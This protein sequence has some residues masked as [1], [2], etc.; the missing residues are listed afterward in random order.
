MKRYVGIDVAQEESALCIVNVTGTILFVGSCA[1][2][3]D[4]IIQTIA[5]HAGDEE[6]IVH[7]SGLPLIWLTRELIKR[8]ATLF[9]HIHGSC[10]DTKS[11]RQ[12][13]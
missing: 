3:P 4:E 8:V 13:P 7:D 10:C 1:T 6:K 9:S 2:D 5:T 11:C 12:V